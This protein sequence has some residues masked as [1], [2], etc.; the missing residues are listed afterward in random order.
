[1]D[2][3]PSHSDSNRRL[4]WAVTR[5]F[6]EVDNYKHK[7][8]GSR[9]KSHWNLF[10][11]L[12]SLF[13]FFLKIIGLYE[14]G[15]NNAKNIVINEI[16]LEYDELPLSFNGY[17]IL[18]LTDLHLDCF[19]GIEEII[20]D[21]ISNLEYDICV[22][23]GDF[24]QKT[25]GGFKQII[26]QMEKLAA[27]FQARDGVIAVLGNHDTYLM[28]NWLEK[29]GITVLANETATIGRGNE[30]IAITGVDDPHYYYTDQAINSLEENIDIFKIALVHSPELYDIAAENNYSLYLCG[31]TH[32]GQICLPG[33]IPL[34]THLYNGGNFYRG[35]WSYSRMKGYTNQGCGVVSIPIRFN[36]ESEIA[37]ITLDRKSS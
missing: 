12:T 9:S 3:R 34:I 2:K 24:R 26:K 27:A 10:E 18:H 35:L 33:G 6:L 15:F 29:L 16:K 31:H 23:T 22:L 25:Q 37:L 1:M 20:C 13:C 4:I 5:S 14:R 36:C 19:K 11:N 21:R 8:Y 28:V 7:R 30:K 32:G 17:K